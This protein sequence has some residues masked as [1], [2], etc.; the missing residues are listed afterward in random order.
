VRFPWASFTYALKE[1][2]RF[3]A[4]SESARAI[5]FY[6]EDAATFMYFQPILEE[7]TKVLGRTVCYLTSNFDDPVLKSKNDKIKAFYIGS[8]AIRNFLFASLRADVMVMTMPDLQTFHIKRSITHP[9]HYVYVFHSM[10]SAHLTDRKGAFDHYDTILCVGPYHIEEIR[11]TESAYGLKPKNLIEHGYGILDALLE[12]AS[13]RKQKKP[14]GMAE[15]KHILVAPSWGK[16]GLLETRM[17]VE[18]SEI[19]LGAGYRVTVRPHPTTILKQPQVIKNL[20]NKFRGNHNFVLETDIRSHDSFFDAHCMISDWSGAALEYAFALENPVI[21]I[22]TPL[23]IRNPHFRDIPCE[24]LE[25]KIRNEIGKIVSID[26]L[27]EIPKK[28]ESLY[29]DIDNFRERVRKI[30]ART[31]FNV[32]KSGMVAAHHI[33][34][35]ADKCKTT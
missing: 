13:L 27:G 19:L 22:D 17:G 33:A 21:F 4:L 29:A 28:I 16:R 35:I 32:G 20:D 6:A 11:A 8:G 25:I 10:V 1:W 24:P 12:E 2:R 26:Q 15:K 31:I 23:K 18:L 14:A 34:K 30:R 3:K 7:L 9:V 5:I